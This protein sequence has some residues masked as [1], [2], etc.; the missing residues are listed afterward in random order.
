MGPW[1]A[2]VLGHRQ[3][4]QVI[5]DHHKMAPG[6]GY[7]NAYNEVD[8]TRSI[9]YTNPA[10]NS[11]LRV[12]EGQEMVRLRLAEE[13]EDFICFV[14]VRDKVKTKTMWQRLGA[15]Q[16]DLRTFL[17]TQQQNHIHVVPRV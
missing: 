6:V 3:G 1:L 2:E 13:K 5:P 7:D 11:D 9:T 12:A 10:L 15:F 17:Q 16:N 8:T 14:S 4:T